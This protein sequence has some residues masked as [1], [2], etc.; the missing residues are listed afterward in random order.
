[1][2]IDTTAVLEIC[3]A[4]ITVNSKVNGTRA[5]GNVFML[6]ADETSLLDVTSIQLYEKEYPK[7]FVLTSS[8]LAASLLD[9]STILLSVQSR[10]SSTSLLKR[11]IRLLFMV[12]L[13]YT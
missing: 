10:V 1:M 12:S 11:I 13:R 8:K 2:C 7:N 5:A 9:V 3:D 4:T 6:V